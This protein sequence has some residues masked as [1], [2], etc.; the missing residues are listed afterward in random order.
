MQLKAKDIAREPIKLGPDETV[1]DARNIM[2][3]Y[4]ISR[5]VIADKHNK[6]VGIITEKDI[7]RF[8]YQEVPNRHLNEIRLDEVM[9]KN[10]IIVTED[11]DVSSCAKLMLQNNVSSMIVVNNEKNDNYSYLTGIFTK[12]D[13][14]EAYARHY[15]G[16]NSVAQYMAK[17]VFT[18][19][20]D[21]T[22]HTALMLMINNKV[23]RVVVV[24]KNN[25]PIGIITG[26]D[27]L[28]ISASFGTGGDGSGANTSYWTIQEKSIG[29]RKK[30][31]MFIPSGIKEMF[32]ARDVMTYD[33]IGIT[34]DSNLSEAALIMMRNRISGIPVIDSDNNLAG[35]ITKTDIIRALADSYNTLI[36][37]KFES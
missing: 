30:E 36:K 27:L 1:Y 24:T 37:D 8:L 23:S 25:K 7:A 10:L 2:M 13:L 17:R 19:A 5:V 35:I 18:V 3:K 28:P 16:K 11:Q 22:I 6:A 26:H 12:S 20:P 15:I 21:E 32:L 31:H 4:N 29:N 14:V 9:S 34:K 33:P